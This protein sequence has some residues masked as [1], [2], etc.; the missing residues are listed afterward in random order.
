M[1][2]TLMWMWLLLVPFAWAHNEAEPADDIKVTVLYDNTVLRDDLKSDWGY[3]CLIEGTEKTILFDAGT[4]PD[5]FYHNLETLKVDPAKVEIV[6]ISHE[7][8]DHTGGMPELLKQNPD[9]SVYYPVSFSKDFVTSVKKAKA[10]AVPVDEPVEICKDV[11]STGEVGTEIKEQALILRTSEGL[12][13]MTGCAHPGIVEMLERA[14]TV[15][16]ED[17][18]MVFGG[19]HLMQHS[20][21]AVQKIIKKFKE[22]GVEKCGATHCTGGSQIEMFRK[23][24]GDDFVTMGAGKVLMFKNPQ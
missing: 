5:I 4:Q 24:Y 9:V 18:Y 15:L 13:L 21:E 22:L 10:K 7:H 6:A 17:I 11:F 20:E 2:K 16:D 1:K 12:V 3:S 14:K 19:F 23:A 8:G